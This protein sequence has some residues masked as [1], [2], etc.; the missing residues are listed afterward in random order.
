MTGD[1]H[2]RCAALNAAKVATRKQRSGMIAYRLAMAFDIEHAMGDDSG[3][4]LPIQRLLT[5]KKD[6]EAKNWSLAEAARERDRLSELEPEYLEAL[7]RADPS[8]FERKHPE[9]F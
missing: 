9:L 4:E 5:L 8:V 7:N 6:I 1:E 3:A 2:T